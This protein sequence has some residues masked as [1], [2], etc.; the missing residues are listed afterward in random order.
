MRYDIQEFFKFT[1]LY[2]G[3]IT[4]EVPQ[5]QQIWVYCRGDKNQL[6]QMIAPTPFTLQDDIFVLG[7]GDFSKGTGWADA[8]LVLP[9]IFDGQPGGNYYFEYED[10]HASVASGREVWGYP[11]V[12]AHIDW[13]NRPD[14]IDIKVYDYDT[15]IFSLKL[16]YGDG[17]NAT[18]WEHLALYPQYQV[19]AVP[20]I[21]GSGFAIMDVI[22][23]DPSRD[24]SPHRTLLARAEID[25]GKVDLSNNILGAERLQILEILGAEIRIGDYRSTATNGVPQKVRSLL[26]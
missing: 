15:L 1:G 25:I 26:S 18:A 2:P 3:N 8:S 19:R 24:Y 5:L 6:A 13:T 23:R 20:E 12:L 22:T 17:G 14:G 16:D 10:Q 11:K 21:A 4:Y 9:I 7:V